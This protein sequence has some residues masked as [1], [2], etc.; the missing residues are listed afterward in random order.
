MRNTKNK[1]PGRI[2]QSSVVDQVE[3]GNDYCRLTLHAPAITPLTQPGQFVHLKVPGLGEAVLRRPF[4]VFKVEQDKLVILYRDLGLGTHRMRSLRSGDTV[5]LLG[6][7]GN[8]FPPV[9]EGNYPVLV[10]GGYGMAPLLMTAQRAPEPGMV[11]IGAASAADILCVNDFEQLNWPVKIA[12][13]DGS[14]GT[15]GLVS[16]ILRQW[17]RNEAGSRVLEF[18]AC[19]PLGMLRATSALA[20]EINRP[21]WVSLDQR[22]GCGLGACLGCVQKVRAHDSNDGETWKWARVCTDGPVFDS[23]DIVWD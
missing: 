15:R 4:S 8:G 16:D 2:E 17:L 9:A 19:G 13:E 6:P 12:T 22:M 10:A 7:L 14:A 1:P 20:E 21:A 23:R 5:S 18:F 11:F 3:L